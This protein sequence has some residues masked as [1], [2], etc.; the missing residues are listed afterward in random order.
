MTL[1]F[2]RTAHP[3][4][5]LASLLVIGLAPHSPSR[6]VEIVPQDSVAR[7]D[8]TR[9]ATE[10]KAFTDWDSRNS[11][12][13]S[14]VLFVGSSSI[15]IWKTADA[16]PQLPV[17]NRGFG[18]SHISDVLHYYDALF[19]AHEPTLIVLY[20]GENDIASGLALEEALN[21]YTLLLDR[22]QTDFPQA[23]VLYLSIKA[24]SSQWCDWPRMNA[25]NQR[26]KALH[27]QR[28]GHHYQ[29][30]ATS[31]QLADGRPDDTLFLADR[32]HL[33]PDGYARW[34]KV[35]GEAL[36]RILTR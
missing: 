2:F 20:M 8:P 14:S 1:S 25:F 10:I 13:R 6:Q 19:L 12:P 17:V 9:F 22:I 35:V 18:G 30:V 24:S 15:R 36:T 29:D 34:Q 3:V 26:V 33:N 27:G 16:F 28:E 23:Q 32:L 11:S 7:P 4:V 21:D 5:L 31:L